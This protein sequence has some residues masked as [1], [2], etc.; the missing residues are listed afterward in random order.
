MKLTKVEENI[1]PESE[2]R[3]VVYL[4]VQAGLPPG[5]V[6]V[7]SGF[8]STAGASLCRHMDVDKVLPNTS[9]FTTID[10]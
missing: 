9:F 3:Y 5:V 4:R 10:M 6:N 1:V 2:V 8:G 7:I